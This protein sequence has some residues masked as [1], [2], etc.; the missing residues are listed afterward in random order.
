MDFFAGNIPDNYDEV[1]G[2][3]LSTKENLSKDSSMSSTK[4]SIVYYE[5]IECNN[6]MDVNN[7]NDVNPALSY[8]T[9]QE[10]ALRVNKTAEQQPNM[11]DQCSNLKSSEITPQ[12]VLTE[13]T[14][15]NPT[16]GQATCNEDDNIIN[17]QLP[18]NL[19]ALTE[20]GLWNSSFHPISL[21]RLIE[22]IVSD[23]K[24][25]KDSLNF[26]AKYISNKQI[27]SSKSN[28]LEDL[29]GIGKAVWNFTGLGWKIG[30]IVCNVC[31][32]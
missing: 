15:S 19:N 18:Y 9:S 12:C 6:A 2:R 28:D 27:N 17:I 13:H 25:I 32:K 5:K 29:H 26:M 14:S 30:Y 22:H 23:S 3:S 31:N 7:V 4:S 11:R 24:N 8:E 16:H 1:R 10:L 21:H 20:L